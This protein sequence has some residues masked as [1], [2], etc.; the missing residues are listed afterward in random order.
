M[1]TP[2]TTDRYRITPHVTTGTLGSRIVALTGEAVTTLDGEGIIPFVERLHAVVSRDAGADILEITRA[3]DA[4]GDVENLVALLTQLV[5]AGIV[6]AVP[7]ATSAFALLASKQS[8]YQ[9]GI[10]EAQRNIDDTLVEI[11]GAD[12]SP[13]AVQIQN[14]L[15]QQGMAVTRLATRTEDVFRVVVGV[16]HVDPVLAA[17]NARAL[18]DGVPWLAV[19]PFDGRN[20]WTGPFMV[21]R[22]SACF[23]CFRLRRSANFTDEVMRSELSEI[24]MLE[25]AGQPVYEHPVNIVQAGLVA[26]LVGEWVALRDYAP[27]AVPGGMSVLSLDDRGIGLEQHRALRVP[28]CPDCSLSATTGLPQVWFHAEEA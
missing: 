12:E 20:A 27:S 14:A 5:D 7:P 3:L 28:R 24:R 21:P 11:S 4:E 23:T 15:E 6:I 26:N 8:G 2:G 18:D 16:S 10:E 13:L 17:A 9:V 25:P 19:A 22:R 1:T